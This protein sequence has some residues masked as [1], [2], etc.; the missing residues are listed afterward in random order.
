MTL[1]DLIRAL[2][3]EVYENLKNAIATGR[4]PDGRSLQEGQRELCMEAVIHYENAHDVPAEQRV[5]YLDQGCKTKSDD[6]DT[7][8]LTLQ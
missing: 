6:D 3:P 7:Q 2:T 8:T 1:D 5:G 4:W